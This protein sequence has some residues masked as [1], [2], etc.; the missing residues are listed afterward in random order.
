[1]NSG[2]WGGETK[3]I[4]A[5]FHCCKSR[6]IFIYNWIFFLF[7]V[8]PTPAPSALIICDVQPLMKSEVAERHLKKLQ[9]ADLFKSSHGNKY[10]YLFQCDKFLMLC[11]FMGWINGHQRGAS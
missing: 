2:L 6:F 4:T 11:M 8:N 10:I 3:I 9:S 5:N 7:L 1:M